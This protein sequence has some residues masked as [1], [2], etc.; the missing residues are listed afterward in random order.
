MQADPDSE[1]A[2]RRRMGVFLWIAIGQIISVTGSALV[3]FV[4]GVWVYQE[5]QSTTQFALISLATMLPSLLVAPLVGALIDRWD[6]RWVMILADSGAGVCTA[7]LAALMHFGHLR[8]GHIYLLMGASSL[9]RGFQVPAYLASISL[10]VP[11]EHLGRANGILQFESVTTYLLSPALA[12]WLMETIGVT[13]VMLIDLGTFLFA[14]LTLLSVRFP[15]V[16]PSVEAE[17]SAQRNLWHET[18]L[19]W[20]FIASRE[21][22][23]GI[24]TLFALGNYANLMTDTLMPPMLLEVSSPGTLGMV[25]SAGGLGM[26]CGTVLVSLWGGPRRRIHAVLGFKMLAGLAIILIGVLRSVPLIAMATFAYYF[27][28]PLVNSND[29]AIWQSKVPLH[30]Q[31]RVF[32]IRRML[33]RAMIPLAYLTAGPLAD[34]IF[35]PLLSEG[36]ALASSLGRY[37]GTGPER[38]IGLLIALMGLFIALLTLAT[39]L[40]P[41]VRLVED[42]LPDAL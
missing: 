4:L 31:G 20:K 26:L 19:G 3:G 5:T 8:I 25:L 14:V 38:G 27:P 28:F 23:V 39:T 2:A 42:E 34:G 15:R 35:K 1:P 37:Y 6:R 32:A 29:Q 24:L 17:Q 11:K 30:M 40:N 9:L 7:I 12:G 21:G 22:L 41:R 16:A 36:G 18:L 10:L 33:V 13:G